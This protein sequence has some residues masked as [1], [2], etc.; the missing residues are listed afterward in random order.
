MRE[1]PLSMPDL[2][3]KGMCYYDFTNS[4]TVH[5]RCETGLPFDIRSS[6]VYWAG[7][8]LKIGTVTPAK[9]GVPA[10]I[11]VDMAMSDRKNPMLATTPMSG[12]VSV[13]T[14]LGFDVLATVTKRISAPPAT[15]LSVTV[16][17]KPPSQQ[18]RDSLVVTTG[19]AANTVGAHVTQIVKLPEGR[20]VDI[21]LSGASPTVR[22]AAAAGITLHASARHEDCPH[23]DRINLNDILVAQGVSP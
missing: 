2:G 8:S 21:L 1:I 14:S 19:I 16:T 13:R 4:N 20:R 22:S 5:Y 23:K 9:G 10:T 7:Q 18:A 15:E 3:G 17:P 12:M 6:G 11:S